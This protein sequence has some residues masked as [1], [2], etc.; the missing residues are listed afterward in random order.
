MPFSSTRRYPL[1]A[2]YGL[3][4]LTGWNLCS[5]CAKVE[6]EHSVGKFLYRNTGVK[7]YSRSLLKHVY[8]WL[9]VGRVKKLTTSTT[10]IFTPKRIKQGNFKMLIRLDDGITVLSPVLAV[11]V[12]VNTK[13]CGYIQLNLKESIQSATTANLTATISNAGEVCM[14]SFS[15]HAFMICI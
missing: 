2:N 7:A 15:M 6:P 13:G 14:W 3:K 9:N 4:A 10:I 12:D 1:I 11:I 8:N 5:S